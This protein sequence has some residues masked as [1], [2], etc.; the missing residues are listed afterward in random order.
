[1]F[2]QADP[3]RTIDIHMCCHQH[4][5]EM[6]GL[7]SPLGLK[8]SP[9]VRQ[10]I[11]AGGDKQS[12]TVKRSPHICLSRWPEVRQQGDTSQC[13]VEETRKSYMYTAYGAFRL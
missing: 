1:M 11:S 13:M 9:I 10:H 3:S 7:R 2:H 5:E 6:S 12:C 8:C 4:S